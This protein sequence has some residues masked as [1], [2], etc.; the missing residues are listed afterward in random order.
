MDVPAMEYVKKCHQC[1]TLKAKQQRAPMESIVATHPLELVHINYL[2]LEPGKG[3][4]GN[5]LV[6]TDNFTQLPRHISIS[7]GPDNGQD[8]MVQFPHPLQVTRE[9]PFGPGEELRE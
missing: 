2:L 7:D 4:E 1:V 3:K 8:L 5:V 9:N 6:V